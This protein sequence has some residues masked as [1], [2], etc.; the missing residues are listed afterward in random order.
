MGWFSRLFLSKSHVQERPESSATTPAAAPIQTQPEHQAPKRPTAPQPPLASGDNTISS[1]QRDQVD[2]HFLAWLF[3]DGDKSDLFKDGTEQD[4]LAEVEKAIHSN[5]AGSD[6]VRRMPGVIPHLL[7]SLRTED[8][9]GAELARQISHDVVLVAEIIRIANSSLFKT[10]ENITS[11]E[12]AVM[13]LG[14][15]GLRQ[16]ITSVAF[17]PIIDLKSGHFTRTIAPKIW[18]HSEKCARANRMLAEGETV[19]AFEAFLAG[20][21]Q[22]VGLIVSLRFIDQLAANHHVG[23]PAFCDSLVMASRKLSVGI[24]REWYFPDTV[25]NAIEEQGNLAKN[26]NVSAI[27]AIL[28]IGDYISKIQILSEHRRLDL[29][30]AGLVDGLS[31]KALLCLKELES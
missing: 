12:R 24:A 23:S 9:S 30:D 27:G 31:E 5:H 7:Q 6:M 28:S 17:K 11:I 3:E 21:I 18:S 4:I 15:T 2:A 22:D 8:F 29:D 20:L 19:Q 25:V 16:L 10:S 26:T 13:V 14:H 1:M